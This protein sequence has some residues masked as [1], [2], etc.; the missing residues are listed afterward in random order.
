MGKMLLAFFVVYLIG[1]GLSI[2]SEFTYHNKT[3]AQFKSGFK[4]MVIKY[5]LIFAVFITA[6]VLYYYRK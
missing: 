1:L 3:V 6:S 2:V 5:S 4:K